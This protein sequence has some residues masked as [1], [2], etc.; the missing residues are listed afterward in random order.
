MMET[1]YGTVSA[2][3]CWDADYPDVVSQAGRS[4]VDLLFVSARDWAEVKDIHAQMA[5]FRAVENGVPIFRQTSNGVSLVVD[6][7]GREINYVDSFDGVYE[8]DVLVPLNATGTVYPEVR[9]TFGW[10]AVL[11]FVGIVIGTW[12]EGRA[13]KRRGPVNTR[14]EV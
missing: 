8:Q 4:D 2:I 7:Y 14:G 10:M 12:L 9:D 5:V 6:A 3:I 13:D 1:P 11:G